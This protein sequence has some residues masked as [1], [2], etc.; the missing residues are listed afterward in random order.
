MQEGWKRAAV[1]VAVLALLVLYTL[2]RGV[3]ERAATDRLEARLGGYA[4]AGA[5]EGEIKLGNYVRY[6]AD[7]R[8]RRW[9]ELALPTAPPPGVPPP[10]G[11][12]VI[13]GV[14]VDPGLASQAAPGVRR[15]RANQLPRIGDGGCLVVNVLYDPSRDDIIAAWCNGRLARPP[16]DR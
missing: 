6:Y 5:Q 12:T 1:L 8:P 9:G 4:V 7:M 13:V 11:K 14:L 2:W 3:P 15:V 16:A 10:T